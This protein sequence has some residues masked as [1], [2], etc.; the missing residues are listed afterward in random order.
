M[1]EILKSA[2]VPKDVPW[3]VAPLEPSTKSSAVPIV[4]CKSPASKSHC[5]VTA[6][7]E[8]L[9]TRASARRC[10]IKRLFINEGQSRGMD[11]RSLKAAQCKLS[12]VFAYAGPALGR[13]ANLC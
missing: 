12:I 11:I 8:I 4:A 9:A 7:S 2:V 3:E 13:E 1:A 10:G 5:P 6:P